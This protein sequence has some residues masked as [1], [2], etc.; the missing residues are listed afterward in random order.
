MLRLQGLGKL[1]K[2]FW[3]DLQPGM[4][5][6][7]GVKIHGGAPIELGNFPVLTA[8]LLHRLDEKY[9]FLANKEILVIE[10]KHIS[11]EK[12]NEQIYSVGRQLKAF[13]DFRSNY[14]EALENLHKQFPPLFN[15]KAKKTL[16]IPEI[17]ENFCRK[18][19]YN[20][21]TFS[22]Q[23]RYPSLLHE[24][25][26]AVTFSDLFT[27]KIEA[28]FHLPQV[29]PLQMHI[30]IDYSESME[31]TGFLKNA[32][33]AVNFIAEYLEKFFPK[34]ELYIY[35]FSERC[36]PVPFPLSGK[37]V[38]RKK[39]SYTNFFKK[40][41]HYRNREFRNIA[42]VLTDGQGKDWPESLEIAP[43]C[44]KYEIDYI[45]LVIYPDSYFTKVDKTDYSKKMLELA[46]LAHGNQFTICNSFTYTILTEAIDKY[47]GDLHACSSS[48][49]SPQSPMQL[50][51][52]LVSLAK[53]DR[54]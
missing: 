49:F 14:R 39:T 22:Q 35:S 52:A 2:I 41:L 23:H 25:H 34:L 51:N 4:V 1:R 18:N 15:R 21:F 44:K 38:Q 43:R 3:K 29:D 7:G 27:G 46:S 5:Y 11:P 20:T 30:G 12:F 6:L 42:I 37:E 28:K 32:I 50:G 47:L 33:Q 9:K 31:K 45:Q 17:Q 24:L 36:R 26:T 54:K 48:S 10:T 8:T 53:K 13:N 19:F 40:V 16:Y